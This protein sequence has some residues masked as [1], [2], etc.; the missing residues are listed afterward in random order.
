MPKQDYDFS[1]SIASNIPRVVKRKDVA[2]LLGVSERTV[3]RMVQEGSLPQPLR[4][5]KG[6]QRGWIK[7]RLE[8][9]LQAQH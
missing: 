9:F 5:P 1:R 8:E 3:Y 2:R 4:S 6:Y 7:E